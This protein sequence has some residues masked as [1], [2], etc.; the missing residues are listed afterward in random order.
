MQSKT[1]NPLFATLFTLAAI[2]LSCKHEVILDTEIQIPKD[3]LVA[4]YPFKGNANDASGNNHNGKVFGASLTT[5]RFGQANNAYTFNGTD[6]YIEIDDND[7]FSISSTGKLSISVWMRC[8]ALDFTKSEGGYVHWMGKGV[9]DQ[10]EW[11]TRIYNLNSPRPNRISCYSFNLSGGLGAGSYV[12]EKTTTGEWIH[13]VAIY[14][15]PANTI[16]IYKN[17]I[18]KDTDTF[19]GYTINPQNGTAPVRIGTRDFN[20]FFQGAVDDLRIYSRVLNPADIHA[21]YHESSDVTR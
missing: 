6:Q 16:M 12:Q 19:S 10:H 2:S 8:D 21:L 15:F 14:N 3:S 7:V 13:I 4:Y 18:L 11:T 1:F 17:G 20:S 9:P 5:N